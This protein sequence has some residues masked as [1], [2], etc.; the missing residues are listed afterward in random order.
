MNTSAPDTCTCVQSPT[1]M[2]QR[3][4]GVIFLLILIFKDHSESEE[5]GNLSL[6]F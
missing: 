6:P 4:S 3:T 1:H 2:A 5:G